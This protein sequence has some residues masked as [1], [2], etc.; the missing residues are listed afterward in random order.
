MD[1]E[2]QFLQTQTKALAFTRRRGEGASLQPFGIEDQAR[3]IPEQD[4][5][6]IAGFVDKDK[7]KA[8][9]KPLP[10]AWSTVLDVEPGTFDKANSAAAPRGPCR[11]GT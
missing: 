8:A 5:E 1:Q 2:R 6:P 7:Q 4:F 11:G 9:A 3:A 10:E